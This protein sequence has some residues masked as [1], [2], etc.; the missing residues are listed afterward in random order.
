MKRRDSNTLSKSL[1]N[2]YRDPEGFTEQNITY[3]IAFRSAFQNLLADI[4]RAYDGML[5]SEL[6]KAGTRRVIP[7]G[8]LH[9]DNR[10]GIRS[11]Q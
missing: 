5:I 6:G 3:E 1:Q 10:G 7:D 8:T 9:D 11:G 4:A 2:Y